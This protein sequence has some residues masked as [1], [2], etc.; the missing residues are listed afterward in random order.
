MTRSVFCLSSQALR[1]V[2]KV[3]CFGFFLSTAADSERG[4]RDFVVRSVKNHYR[5]TE[6]DTAS[7]PD[8]AESNDVKS[9]CMGEGK[10]FEDI[11][12]ANTLFV[13]EMAF[14]AAMAKVFD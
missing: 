3:F 8:C 2:W 12:T 5:C 10:K 1:K 6:T 7:R 11:W 13:H 4:N 9:G 14:T